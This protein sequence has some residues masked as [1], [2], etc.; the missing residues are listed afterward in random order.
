LY[1]KINQSE[2]N[3]TNTGTT[4]RYEIASKTLKT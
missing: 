3:I 4:L 2:I 1:S